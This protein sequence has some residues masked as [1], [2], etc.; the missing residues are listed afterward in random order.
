MPQIPYTNKTLSRRF[1]GPSLQEGEFA[2][3]SLLAGFKRPAV[4]ISRFPPAIIQ[5]PT[6]T[7]FGVIPAT[8]TAFPGVYSG[9]PQPTISY[10]WLRDGIPFE[11][12]GNTY[13][14]QASDD[15]AK[16]SVRVTATSPSGTIIT[17][18]NTITAV[19]YEEVVNGEFALYTVTGM[20]AP[21]KMIGNNVHA[22]YVTGMAQQ[23]S[24]INSS[25]IGYVITGMGQNDQFYVTES[26]IYIITTE[27]V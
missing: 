12:V 6:V 8:L 5:P 13:V 21:G 20:A 19:L 26:E 1:L 25:Y 16:I 22:Y 4:P 3:P 18:S 17:T 15:G 9:S 7:G 27:G 23:L 10:E 2:V 24:Q 11:N 14:T